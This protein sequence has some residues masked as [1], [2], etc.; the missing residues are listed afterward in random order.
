MP[1]NNYSNNELNQATKLNSNASSQYNKV[2]LSNNVGGGGGSSGH[3][4]STQISNVVS[5][6]HNDTQKKSMKAAASQSAGNS[7]MIF[8]RA[9]HISDDNGIPT[10]PKVDEQR[11]CLKVNTAVATISADKLIQDVTTQQQTCEMQT[12]PVS[13]MQSEIG[14]HQAIGANDAKTFASQTA[15]QPVTDKS[16]ATF[17]GNA[18]SSAS[19]SGNAVMIPKGLFVGE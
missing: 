7:T 1:S 12:V 9:Q 17:W 16:A 18:E 10:V 15:A 19:F 13:E 8:N 2:G 14:H 5:S 4:N 6:N 3:S 11:H